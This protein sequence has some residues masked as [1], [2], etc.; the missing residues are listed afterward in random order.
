M[1]AQDNMER[2]VLPIP[3]Q[4]RTGLIC[5]DA[6][7]PENKYP[8]I[9]PLRPPA[10][11]PNVLLVLI[12]D[13]GFG[14]SSA[15]GG[16]CNTPTAERVGGRGTEIHPISYD[17]ALLT[18][19]TGTAD[20]TQPPH[21]RDGRDYRNR[22]RIAWLQLNS[23]EYLLR[24]LRG[25]SSLTGTRQ[26]SSASAMKCRCGKPVRP[27]PSMRGLPVEAD[28][29]ISTGSLEVRRTNGTHRCM[30]AP[31]RS[32]SRRRPKRATT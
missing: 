17:G 10:G 1:S 6:K 32:R 4:P 22:Q 14:S 12:D 30:R 26:R 2:T 27:V 19:A 21:G 28:S 25:P 7:D 15:F 16:P 31:P 29:N 13:A 5:Y 23:A 11:A 24:P 3:D 9:T 18:D 8:T 20:R